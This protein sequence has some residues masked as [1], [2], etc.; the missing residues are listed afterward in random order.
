MLELSNISKSFGSAR[1][2]DSVNLLIPPGSR[3][4]IVG[5]SGSGKTTLL[6]LIAGFER[7]DSGQIMMHG[8]PL[9]AGDQ[10]VPAHQRKIGFVPQEG[11]LFPH[12]RVGENIAWGLSGSRHEKRER[13]GA[14]M[15]MVSLDSKLAQRWPHEI[16]G[17]QQQRVALARALAQQPSLMLL[18]EPFS[19]LDTGLRA[20]TR[21]ATADLLTQAGVASIL[22]TH[23]QKEA[24]SFASQIAVI[25]HGRFAQIGSPFEVYSQPADEETALFL[26]DALIMPAEVA[27]GKARCQLGDIPVDDASVSG[28]RRIM[29]R[30]EQISVEPCDSTAGLP[31]AHIVDIDFVGYLSALTL[32]FA[33]TDEQITVQTVTRPGW[34]PGMKV[35]IQINGCARVFAV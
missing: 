9:F 1:V 32:A 19:A 13:V 16:S 17:G 35:N 7:P 27:Q 11:A 8:K 10:F 6:R 15:A 21:K 2:L 31:Q 22:V 29:L 5:P 4:A 20:A 28:A 24:L 25:R 23:D 30:P 3:T 33:H 12:L 26:G 18:D 34:L 14:L